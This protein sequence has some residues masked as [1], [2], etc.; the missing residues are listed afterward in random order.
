MA[1]HIINIINTSVLLS[2]YF[3]MLEK[4]KSIQQIII[5]KIQLKQE[6]YFSLV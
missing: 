3:D 5:F 6:N 1:L 4:K 2:L